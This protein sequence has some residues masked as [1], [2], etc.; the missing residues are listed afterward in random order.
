MGGRWDWAALSS[1]IVPAASHPGPLCPFFS[2]LRC[3]LDAAEA[4]VAALS[5]EALALVAAGAAEAGL[6][7]AAGV[8][9][10]LDGVG[11][12]RPP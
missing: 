4:A 11:Q 9:E 2:S 12:P 6:V 10:V 1:P 8:V 3:R 7:D 5:P